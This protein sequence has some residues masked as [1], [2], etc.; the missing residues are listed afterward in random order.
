[1]V[2]GVTVGLIGLQERWDTGGLDVQDAGVHHFTV[3]LHHHLKLLVINDTVC[4]ERERERD[5][6]L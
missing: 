4:R 2:E 1:M 3:N 5:I 6:C